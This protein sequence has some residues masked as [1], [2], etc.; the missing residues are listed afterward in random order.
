MSAI[1]DCP[2]YV[3]VPNDP[4]RPIVGIL[5][6]ADGRAEERFLAIAEELG[7]KSGEYQFREMVD[8]DQLY[9]NDGKVIHR[10]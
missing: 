2:K 10:P 7:F 8:L 4:S 3:I 9:D 6:V 5:T 1:T